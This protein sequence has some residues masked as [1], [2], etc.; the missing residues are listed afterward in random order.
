[1]RDEGWDG[2]WNGDR[3]RDGFHELLAMERVRG[4]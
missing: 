1:M 3:D 4:F 2:R